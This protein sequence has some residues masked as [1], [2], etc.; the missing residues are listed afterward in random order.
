M[1]LKAK[2]IDPNN[3][4]T[5]VTCS[6]CGLSYSARNYKILYENEKLAFF[7][8]KLPNQKTKIF[9]HDCLHKVIHKHMGLLKNVKLEIFTL[10]ETV[11]VFFKK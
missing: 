7:K 4:K 10:D 11:T 9:C 2:I 6:E 5:R 1:D 8:M 3:R